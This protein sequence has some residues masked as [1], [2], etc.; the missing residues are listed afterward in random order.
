MS[1]SAWNITA[2]ELHRALA[3]GQ[4]IKLVDVREPEEFAESRIE[5]GTLIPLGELTV[6]ARELSPDDDIVL[7]CAHGV[8]S[9]H[10]LLALQRLGFKRLRS[11]EG[12]ICEW[13]A[14][15]F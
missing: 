8:R 4:A 5:G 1:Q 14:Q 7:Y 11:L 13:Q 2:S 9:V 15:G 6:R 3:Q 10:A 12:G